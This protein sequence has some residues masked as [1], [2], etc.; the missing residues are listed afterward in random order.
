MYVQCVVREYPINLCTIRK[1]SN[2]DQKQD[3]VLLDRL[4]QY[5]KVP[6]LVCQLEPCLFSVGK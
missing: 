6:S 2:I 3:S 4:S 1:F 5:D